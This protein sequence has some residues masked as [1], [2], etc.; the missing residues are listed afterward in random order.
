MLHS[1]LH[2]LNLFRRHPVDMKASGA[3]SHSVCNGRNLLG[4]I[5]A[6]SLILVTGDVDYGGRRTAAAISC[7][8]GRGVAST[9]QPMCGLLPPCKSSCMSHPTLVA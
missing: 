2:L 8:D 5:A 3:D 1:R 4:Q 6:E 9:M 7:Q